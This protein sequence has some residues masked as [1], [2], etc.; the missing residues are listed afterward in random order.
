M[1]KQINP[2]IKAHLIRGAFYLLLLLAVCAIPFALAQ[3]RSRATAK[4]IAAKPN[5]T[6]NSRVGIRAASQLRND[7][8]RVPAIRLRLRQRVPFELRR[9][10]CQTLKEEH[11]LLRSLLANIPLFTYMIDDGTAEDSVGLT[12][13]G[14]FARLNS[15]PVSGGNNVITSIS[16]AWGTP[17]FPD[18]TLN[19]L[20]YTAVLWSDPNG[21]GSPTDAVVLARLTEWSRR[22]ARTHL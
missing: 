10:S 6:L 16:I 20:P 14:N 2:T 7:V 13:G 4:Q 21:D 9:R 5:Q 3:S 8:V 11:S 17:A 19:G 22:R 15:F 1:K 18:P 12:N